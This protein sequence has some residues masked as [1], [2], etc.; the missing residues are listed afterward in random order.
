MGALAQ[1]QRR[2]TCC[3]SFDPAAPACASA[4]THS[5]DPAFSEALDRVAASAA[6]APSAETTPSAAAETKKEETTPPAV[7]VETPPPPSLPDA[8]VAEAE[9]AEAERA[10]ERARLAELYAK[11]HEALRVAAASATPGGGESS[12]HAVDPLRDTL[13]GIALQHGTTTEALRMLNKLGSDAELYTREWIAVPTP[14]DTTTTSPT[15]KAPAGEDGEKEQLRRAEAM[16]RSLVS[17]FLASLHGED[18]SCTAQEAEAYLSLAA[19]NVGSALEA[20]REDLA[21]EAQHK[22]K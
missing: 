20:M 16:R 22:S 12:V 8:A 7:D 9:R 3:G 21:W 14:R 19:W 17:Q 18:R 15:S 2:W 4:P 5:P 1:L 11:R 6:E 13:Q 10:A